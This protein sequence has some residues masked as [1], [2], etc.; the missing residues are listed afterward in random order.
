MFNEF[1]SDMSCRRWKLTR[2][3]YGPLNLRSMTLPTTNANFLLNPLN[4]IQHSYDSIQWFTWLLLMDKQ[5]LSYEN[6][7]IWYAGIEHQQSIKLS[8]EPTTSICMLCLPQLKTLHNIIYTG[9]C[10]W[11]NFERW[12]YKH[13]ADLTAIW[14]W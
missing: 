9:A 2:N 4:G 10:W 6:N 8:W 3:S 11:G 14:R 12:C 5:L 7:I 1:S 13:P